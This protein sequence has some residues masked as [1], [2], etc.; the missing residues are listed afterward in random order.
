MELPP[1]SK[2]TSPLAPGRYTTTQ[3]HLPIGNSTP[4]SALP[5]HWL[6]THLSHDLAN[7]S[8]GLSE[9]LITYRTL[10]AAAGCL[11]ACHEVLKRLA[12]SDPA[13]A[14]WQRDLSVSL[15]KLGDLAVAQGDLAGALRSFS[16]SKTIRERLAASDP[17][18]AAWQ[19]DLSVSLE[20]LGG[21]AVAQGD[22]AG[23]LRSFSESK[24][25][26]ERLAAS[27]PANAAWQ[28]DLIVSYQKLA[29]VAAKA[30][31]HGEAAGHFAQC[32]LTLRGM[33]E[34]H[35]H[36]DPAL[37]GFLEQLERAAM[38]NYAGL[39][40]A[41]A[42]SSGT[43]SPRPA[44]RITIPDP[45]THPPREIGIEEFRESARTNF[46]KG[47]WEAAASDL[48][49]LLAQGEPLADIAPKIVTC[50]LNAHEDLLPHDAATIEDLLRRLE[51]AGH[52]TPTADLRRQLEAKQP[53][54]PW[55]KLW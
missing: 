30:G 11:A 53:K 45:K 21:L 40:A 19:R 54:K 14:A 43:A 3:P 25:I 34:D 27:D 7:A 18:N 48:Q 28:R 47:Y 55:W 31:E 16:E 50:L 46:G 41:Y 15:E 10:P 2:P 29:K 6:A 22:L 36:L 26:A 17:A 20:K 39:A 33:Q 24:T 37:A 49:K 8:L 35:M 13:N 52:P 9:K 42:S 23:A 12:A 44:P 5:P 1:P 51:S 32:R 4:C 38:E